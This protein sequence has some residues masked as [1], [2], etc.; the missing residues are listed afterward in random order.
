M[1]QDLPTLGIIG[2]GK[3][4][5]TLARLLAN[6]GYRLVAVYNRTPET[7]RLLAAELHTAAVSEPLD[8][9]RAADLT[10]LTVTDDALPVLSAG[11]AAALEVA[12]LAADAKAIVHTSGVYGAEVLASPGQRGMLVGGLHPAFP[13]AAANAPG[14]LRG[15]TFALEAD[16]ALL[17]RWLTEL[18]QALEG[19]VL[20]IPVGSKA[21][22]HA[23]LVFASN[24][25]VVLY[26]LAERLLLGLGA[27]RAVAEQALNALVGATVENLRERGIPWALTGPLARLD[28]GTLAAHLQALHQQSPALAGLYR[29]LARE[30]YPLLEARGLSTAVLEAFFLQDETNAVEHS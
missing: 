13:F 7:A 6:A 4:G 14:S 19:S 16:D 20:R 22:Y 3:V 23:A 18:V 9:L 21:L 17:L 2:T 25:T 27:E 11:I 26:A 28:T 24:Y 30:A 8:V 12:A 10:L 5:S 15:V 29:Q 1:Q